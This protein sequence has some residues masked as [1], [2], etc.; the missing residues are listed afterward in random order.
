MDIAEL[1]RQVEYKFA[2]EPLIAIQALANTY[3]FED[4]EERLLDPD[5]A[6]AWLVESGL[7]RPDVTVDRR[8]HE[9][10]LG[11]REVVRDLLEANLHAE[12]TPDAEALARFAEAHPVPVRVGAG[13]DLDLD[14]E[15][16]A[17][18]DG[19]IAQ[20]LGIV[21]QAQTRGEWPRLKICAFDECRWAFY[22]SSKNRGGTWC[23]M[24][25]CGNRVKNRRY[26]DRQSQRA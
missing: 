3:D 18:V 26:R 16:Q 25:E 21:L 9:E 23:R 19:V 17:D 7:A 5:A 10:L 4:E 20:M 8:E 24:E 11:F 2:P 12:H 15:P 14:L 1:Q 13:G 22:D 6:R